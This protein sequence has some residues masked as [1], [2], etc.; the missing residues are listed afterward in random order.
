MELATNW[1]RKKHWPGALDAGVVVIHT[2]ATA[3]V[4]R[5]MP[6][7]E[8]AGGKLSGYK[9]RDAEKEGT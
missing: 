2:A 1:L 9:D 8:V 6:R 3:T 7:K 5:K 4:A